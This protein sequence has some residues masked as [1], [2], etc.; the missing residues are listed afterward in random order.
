MVKQNA[1]SNFPVMPSSGMGSS[2][3]P[4]GRVSVEFATSE[5]EELDNRTLLKNVRSKG[6]A[7]KKLIIHDKLQKEEDAK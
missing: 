2:G 6:L 4:S 5:E 7:D 1:L 3:V